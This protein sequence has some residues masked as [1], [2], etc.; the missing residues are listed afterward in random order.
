MAL[1]P[2][3]LR[4]AV[5]CDADDCIGASNLAHPRIKCL[6]KA[7]FHLIA[8]KLRHVEDELGTQIDVGPRIHWY[9]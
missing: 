8:L 1:F 4:P 3:L 7:A 2:T 9:L 6:E 5:A